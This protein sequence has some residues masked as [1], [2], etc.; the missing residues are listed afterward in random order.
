MGKEGEKKLR[1]VNFLEKDVWRRQILGSD[2][3]IDGFIGQDVVG[4]GIAGE[5]DLAVE[6]VIVGGGMADGVGI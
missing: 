1:I 3:H 4:V 5:V 6:P 2:E